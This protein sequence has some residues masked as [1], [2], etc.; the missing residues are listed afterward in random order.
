MRNEIIAALT[1]VVRETDG[2]GGVRHFEAPDVAA[3]LTGNPWIVPL[4]EAIQKACAA[5]SVSAPDPRVAALETR[6][7]ELEAQ[8]VA[9]TE[10][11]A[12]V[13]SSRRR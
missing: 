11:L 4:A 12:A 2:Y 5:P 10:A 6:V 1:G 7:V 13:P 8:V 9:L 3:F